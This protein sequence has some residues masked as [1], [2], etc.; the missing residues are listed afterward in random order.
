MEKKRVQHSS[1]VLLTCVP[2]VQPH[3]REDRYKIAINSDDLHLY[4]INKSN[5]KCKLQHFA[6]CQIC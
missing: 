6:A 4:E 1:H 2:K 5:V 3:Y